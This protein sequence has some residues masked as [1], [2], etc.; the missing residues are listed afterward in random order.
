MSNQTITPRAGSLA[1]VGQPAYSFGHLKLHPGMYFYPYMLA[2]LAA[3]A[4][5]TA[6]YD[7]AHYP[8]FL[9]DTLGIFPSPLAGSGTL[10]TLEPVVTLARDGITLPQTE[11][12]SR[13]SCMLVNTAFE[14]LTDAQRDGLKVHKEGEFFRHARHASSHG[15]KWSFLANE[16]K[17]P[18]EWKGVVL[19][20][21]AFQGKRF[22]HGTLTPGDLLFLLADI[23]KLL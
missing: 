20:R 5:L 6:V 23:E 16:P 17:R 3:S 14:S 15:N 8:D 22:I 10:V 9:K 21:V 11:A 19:D 4:G 18:A 7:G 2:Y 12:E 1:A 13:L